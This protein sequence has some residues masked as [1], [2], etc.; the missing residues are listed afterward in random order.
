MTITD[1]LSHLGSGAVVIHR[2]LEVTLAGR[3]AVRL[4]R[5]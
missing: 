2:Y 4:D 3:N 1:L 5:R